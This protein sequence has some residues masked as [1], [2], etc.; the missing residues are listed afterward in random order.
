MPLPWA[1]TEVIPEESE[2]AMASGYLSETSLM[3]QVRLI[4]STDH[5]HHAYT[6]ASCQMK[7]EAVLQLDYLL[8][9][10]CL[11]PPGF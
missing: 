3:I 10:G 4:S 2:R 9:L 7:K 8:T 1:H 6:T 5:Y 11:L